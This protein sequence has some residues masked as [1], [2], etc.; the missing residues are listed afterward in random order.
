M[1]LDALRTGAVNLARAAHVNAGGKGVNVASCLADWGLPVHAHGLLGRDNSSPFEQLFAA[2][3][4]DDRMLR[5]A[6]ACRVNIKL[7]DLETGDTT[8]I[9]LPGPE[10]GE[11]SCRRWPPASPISAPATWRCWPAACRPACR[12]TRWRGCARS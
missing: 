6:G 11:A 9:N 2:K 8:D 3:R 4:I 5:V 12:A 10:T 7:A 1:T